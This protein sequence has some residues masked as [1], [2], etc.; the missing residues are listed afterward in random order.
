MAMKKKKEK[1]SNYHRGFNREIMDLLHKD[2]QTVEVN[3]MCGT[4]E[5]IRDINYKYLASVQHNIWLYEFDGKWYSDWEYLK[6]L[7]LK[8]FV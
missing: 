3:S 1:Y 4:V 6:Y 2:F 7:K 5:V 8:S